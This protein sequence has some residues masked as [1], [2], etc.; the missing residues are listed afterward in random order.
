MA[1]TAK[2]MIIAV[3]S[4][5]LVRCEDLWV[6]CVVEDVKN[7]YGRE[8]LLVRPVVGDGTQWV[9]MSRIVRAL[10]AHVSDVVTPAA[11]VN[12]DKALD[13]VWGYFPA[14]EVTNA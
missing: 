9:E 11:R 4:N 2:Q 1:N 6:T 3:G 5:V 13:V 8:R 14:R 7:S 10:P 12:N